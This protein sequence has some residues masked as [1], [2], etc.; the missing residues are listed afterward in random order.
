MASSVEPGAAAAL[1]RG[2]CCDA[3]PPGSPQ[4]PSGSSS[5]ASTRA[6]SA[7]EFTACR[8]LRR[9]WVAAP[10]R[11]RFARLTPILSSRTSCSSL[12]SAGR[13]RN[14]SSGST[15][16][17]AHVRTIHAGLQSTD[18]A[19][20]PGV[21]CELPGHRAV[22]AERAEVHC[23]NYVRSARALAL[24]RGR[25]AWRFMR[26]APVVRCPST[27]TA[28]LRCITWR[29]CSPR[30]RARAPVLMCRLMLTP[31]AGSLRFKNARTVVKVANILWSQV[32]AAARPGRPARRG[33]LHA[34]AP[35]QDS[36]YTQDLPSRYLWMTDVSVTGQQAR[37]AHQRPLRSAHHIA[38]RRASCACVCAALP[39]AAGGIQGR[40]EDAA[41]LPQRAHSAH[42]AA[43]VVGD[44]GR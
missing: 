5:R 28:T 15:R 30:V 14:T 23:G 37:A 25:T 8:C 18:N 39:S 16:Y 34:R 9:M 10:G 7:S 21:A 26:W 17:E 4:R 33:A 36:V 40:A 22:G 13:G 35:P 24:H 1:V 29:A 38:Y 31:D 6:R 2:A 41:L 32:R 27:C 3:H 42:H 44:R 11:Q 20:D 12:R 43:R 19:G